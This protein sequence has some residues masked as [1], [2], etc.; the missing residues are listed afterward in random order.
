[1]TA[2][3]NYA[4]ATARTIKSAADAQTH[5]CTMQAY[6]ASLNHCIRLPQATLLGGRCMNLLGNTIAWQRFI[7]TDYHYGTSAHKAA[8]TARDIVADDAM[9]ATRTGKYSVKAIRLRSLPNDYRPL[10]TTVPVR[11]T[12]KA[13]RSLKRRRLGRRIGR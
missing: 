12:D 2:S 9:L 10:Q 6:F 7:A 13:K 11:K 3:L 8:R 1:M 5:G 4:N